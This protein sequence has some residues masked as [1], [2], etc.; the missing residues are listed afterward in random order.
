[1]NYTYFMRE[2]E[3]FDFLQSTILPA[4]SARH[5]RDKVLAIWSAGCSSGEEP[6]TLSMALKS[7]F[8]AQ[9]SQW[10]TRILATDISEQ[11][12]SKAKAARY[13]H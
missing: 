1:T 9:F 8:G 4:L 13:K 7:Y 11:A 6:Y 3:Q 10:D 12:M 2:P 5:Q